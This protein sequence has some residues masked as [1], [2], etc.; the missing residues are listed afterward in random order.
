MRLVDHEINRQTGAGD[1]DLRPQH[2]FDCAERDSFLLFGYGSSVGL[3]QPVKVTYFMNSQHTSSIDFAAALGR[4]H[5]SSRHPH[6]RSSIPCRRI[7]MRREQHEPDHRRVAGK[8]NSC[9]A[10]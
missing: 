5:Q 2:R 10:C 9:V 8:T 1:L 6:R 7:G 4:G 3:R